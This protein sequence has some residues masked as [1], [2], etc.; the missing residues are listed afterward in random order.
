MQ[1]R[2]G[3]I[4]HVLGGSFIDFY[5]LHVIFH[6]R[7]GNGRKFTLSYKLLCFL[8]MFAYN[9]VHYF[10]LSNVFTF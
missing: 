4:V 6:I 5:Q 3:Y 9:D 7:F 2:G 10:V 1:V 8:C